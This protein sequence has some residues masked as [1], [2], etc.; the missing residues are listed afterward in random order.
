VLKAYDS[1]AGPPARRC[2][3]NNESADGRGMVHCFVDT[4]ELRR[5]LSLLAGTELIGEL[6]TS[7]GVAASTAA[8]VALPPASL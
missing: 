1:E 6:L 4:A 2:P 3:T 5:L 7:L 8:E